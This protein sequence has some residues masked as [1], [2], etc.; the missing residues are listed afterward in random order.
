MNLMTLGFRFDEPVVSH[1]RMEIN[2]MV[3]LTVELGEKTAK[4]ANLDFFVWQMGGVKEEVADSP[5]QQ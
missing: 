5:S 2:G 3:E 1:V 4:F